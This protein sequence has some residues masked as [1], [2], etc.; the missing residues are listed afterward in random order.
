MQSLQ[1]FCLLA[2]EF[3]SILVSVSVP[4]IKNDTINLVIPWLFLTSILLSTAYNCN[5]VSYL[6]VSK[7][8]KPID[9]VQD[10]ASSGLKWGIN[11]MSW[12]PV[13]GSS[14]DPHVQKIKNKYIYFQDLKEFNQFASKGEIAVLVDKVNRIH[15][16]TAD[17]E[18]STFRK[19]HLMKDDVMTFVESLMFEKGSPYIDKFNEVIKPLRESGIIRHWDNEVFRMYK[20]RKFTYPLEKNSRAP[21]G[22][23]ILELNHVRGGF[24]ILLASYP[25]A[26]GILVC[27]LVARCVL[28]NH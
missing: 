14:A 1:F 27:E 3:C 9:T 4:K 21:N 11:D 20:D 25:L 17:L 5:L 8:Q 2:D 10:L 26:L 19:L 15:L 12:V 24:I 16:S 22:P 13:V 6:T 7:F 18:E 28:K 23:R